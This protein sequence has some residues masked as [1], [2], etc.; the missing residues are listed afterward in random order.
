MFFEVVDMGAITYRG[1]WVLVPKS[2]CN[3]LFAERNLVYVVA[4]GRVKYCL[5]Y[6]TH[7]TIRLYVYTYDVRESMRDGGPILWDHFYAVRDKI[8]LEVTDEKSKM[9]CYSYDLMGLTVRE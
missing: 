8:S 7:N 4:L 3:Y 6:P 2:H 9:V 5:V 1:R